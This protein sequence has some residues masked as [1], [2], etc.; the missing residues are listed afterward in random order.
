MDNRITSSQNI[1]GQIYFNLSQNR[2][3]WDDVSKP[4]NMQPINNM[5]LNLQPINTFN[6]STYMSSNLQPI[7]N[8]PTYYKEP[9]N[10]MQR[11]SQNYLQEQRA[12]LQNTPN[13]GCGCNGAR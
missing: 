8:V 6:N 12:Y 11:V 5:S 2:K 3:W 4:S 13:T 1:N 7:L 9:I 10:P